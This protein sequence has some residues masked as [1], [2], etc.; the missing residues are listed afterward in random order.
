MTGLSAKQIQRY[1]QSIAEDRKLQPRRTLYVSTDAIARE[2]LPQLPPAGSDAE[3]EDIDPFAAF[4]DFEIELKVQDLIEKKELEPPNARK[5]G[6]QIKE[7]DQT[8]ETEK[9]KT[10][11]VLE[12]V[13]RYSAEHVLL[14]G[15]PGSGKT[16]AL[17]R[18]L[19]K[20]NLIEGR[21]LVFLRL[22]DLNPKLTQ[23]VLERL[24]HELG[25]RGL[26]LSLEQLQVLLQQGQFLLL[27]DGIN[28]LPDP[29]LRREVQDFRE[30]YRSTTPMI[31]T[32]RPLNIGVDLGIEQK[33]EMKPLSPKQMQDFVHKHLGLKQGKM[34]LKQLGA[35][36]REF[37]ETP[38]LLWMIC[39]LFDKIKKIP[40]N[41]GLT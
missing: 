21:L 16:T 29:R 15:K 5:N 41:L 13:L 38:L 22:R 2:K 10:Y 27:L 12:G 36:L 14:V 30:F 28:E 31:F 35:R 34:L 32:T 33:L 6:S 1:W 11:G 25:C 18:L 19:T 39:G 26:H 3:V 8:K 40:T 4:A 7:T 17:E 24:Q 9:I 37:G 20:E 23:P